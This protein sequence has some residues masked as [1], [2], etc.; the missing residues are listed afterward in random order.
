M[1]FTCVSNT[2]GLTCFILFLYF[3]NIVTRLFIYCSVVCFVFP[4]HVSWA[5]YASANSFG[6]AMHH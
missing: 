2:S 3:R 6:I 5:V 1:L 4:V